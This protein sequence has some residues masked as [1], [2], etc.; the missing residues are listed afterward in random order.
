MLPLSA[1][2]FHK[3]CILETG[4]CGIFS[5]GAVIKKGLSLSLHFPCTGCSS[6]FPEVERLAVDTHTLV[7]N[8]FSISVVFFIISV[9]LFGTLTITRIVF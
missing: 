4:I 1:F 6:I 9:A 5:T 8:I 7:A 3:N 2:F